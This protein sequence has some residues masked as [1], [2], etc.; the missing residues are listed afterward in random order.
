MHPQERDIASLWDMREAARLIV[1]FLH[2]V[3]YLQSKI[4]NQHF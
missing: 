3:F 4:F 1:S 2:G